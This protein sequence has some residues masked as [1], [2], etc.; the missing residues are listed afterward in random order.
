VRMCNLGAS[1]IHVT[2]LVEH[3]LYLKN[4]RFE[5]IPI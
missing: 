1:L 2:A 5:G 3:R 4:K